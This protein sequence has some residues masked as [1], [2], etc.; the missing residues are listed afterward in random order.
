[1]WC[2]SWRC[3]LGQSLSK[4]KPHVFSRRKIRRA[5]QPRKQINLAIDEEPLDNA[6]RVWSRIILLKYDCGKA[7]KKRKDNWLL[8][9]P[10]M[11][12]SR[13]RE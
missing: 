9:V 5:G 4:H 12:T 7:L 13:M 6:Y 11:R 3:N 1:M 10:G 8:K 2:G